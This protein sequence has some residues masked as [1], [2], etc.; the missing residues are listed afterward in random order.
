MDEQDAWHDRWARQ[1]PLDG[2]GEEGQRALGR[3]TAAVVGAGALGS[4]S[5]ELLARMGIGTVRVIDR[6]VLEAS[7]LHRT[8]VLGAAD[9]GRPKAEALAERLAALAP[10]CRVEGVVEDVTGS[11]ALGLLQG[12]DVVLDG[13]DGM[14]ARFVLNDAC[15][16][17]G[18]PWVY[19]G[20]LAMGG[21]VATFPAGGPCLRCL[22]PEV[23]PDGS[24]PGCESEG[25]HPSAPSLVASVQVAQASRLLL[26][27]RPPPRLLAFDLGADDWRVVDIEMRQGCPACG[28]GRREHLAAG[29]RDIIVT[30][31]GRGAVQISPSARRGPVD[32][33]AK[34]AEWG[35]EGLAVLRRG[36]VLTLDMGETKLHLF[37]SGRALVKGT[38]EQAVAKGMYT[39]Y[40]LR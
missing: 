25:V 28:Q 16:E 8:R 12:A 40:V 27:A 32:L 10:W 35:A 23:P 14:R 26:D 37:A 5:A 11:N 15:L 19:G 6:D 1:L 31:C 2:F 7:N 21:L 17:L 36:P 39:K 30:L 13:L 33:D 4:S 34:A 18:I 29:D 24:V 9:I 3:A 20:V 22:F 38:T